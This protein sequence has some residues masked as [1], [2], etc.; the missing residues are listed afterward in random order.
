MAAGPALH[1]VGGRAGNFSSQASLGSLWN[2]GLGMGFLGILN[3]LSPLPS[4]QEALVA[5]DW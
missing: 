5:L 4:T 2:K 1:V 3:L